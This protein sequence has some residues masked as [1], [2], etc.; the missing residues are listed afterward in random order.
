LPTTVWG[1]TPA[2]ITRGEPRELAGG[3]AWSARIEPGPTSN[4][5]E[6]G[7]PGIATGAGAAGRK[8][9][10]IPQDLVDAIPG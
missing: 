10:L 4:A 6:L 9:G 5:A 2:S 1:N 7:L 8:L 3:H